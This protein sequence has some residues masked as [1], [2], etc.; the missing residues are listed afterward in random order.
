MCLNCV[1]LSHTHSE[2]HFHFLFSTC[3]ATYSHPESFW[4]FLLLYG[5]LVMRQSSGPVLWNNK[6]WAY[7]VFTACVCMWQSSSCLEDPEE[8]RKLFS[9]LLANTEPSSAH[10]PGISFPSWIPSHQGKCHTGFRSLLI[11][12][13]LPFSPCQL[14][15]PLFFQ[16]TAPPVSPDW[17]P[18]LW[19]KVTH[20]DHC[21]CGA[22]VN[23]GVFAM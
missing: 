21:Q 17:L 12:F 18:V 2:K 15:L 13:L 4:H 10:R 11:F 3:Q 5:V 1:K 7:L 19:V 6:Q 9:S 14:L 16:R 22:N 8:E 20:S 23:T